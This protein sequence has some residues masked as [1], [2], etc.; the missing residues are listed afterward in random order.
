MMTEVP[1]LRACITHLLVM[2]TMVTARQDHTSET[3]ANSNSTS[4][5]YQAQGSLPS[6]YSQGDN[7]PQRVVSYT[8]M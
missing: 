3:P 7:W 6:M 8:G 1:S 5:V 4:N 2:V